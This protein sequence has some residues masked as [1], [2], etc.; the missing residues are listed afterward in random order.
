MVVTLE[1]GVL[2]GRTILVQSASLNVPSL[3]VCALTAAPPVTIAMINIARATR[4]RKRDPTVEVLIA[5][6]FSYYC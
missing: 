1:A 3:K 5:L 4:S 2:H 6:T